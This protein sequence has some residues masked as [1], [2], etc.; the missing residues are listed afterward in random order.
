MVFEIHDI[1]YHE[2]KEKILRVLKTLS[3]HFWLVHIHPNNYDA[4]RFWGSTVIANTMELT[5]INKSL[6]DATRSQKFFPIAIDEPCNPK[7]IDITLGL[8]NDE[9]N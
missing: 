2:D 8:W 3:D 6:F 7:T 9:N 4:V 5:W 1:L